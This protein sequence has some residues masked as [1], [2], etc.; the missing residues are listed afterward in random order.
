VDDTLAV[1]RNVGIPDERTMDL[2]AAAPTDRDTLVEA[3]NDI[4]YYDEK[5]DQMMAEGHL[6]SGAPNPFD[7]GP[8]SEDFGPDAGSGQSTAP[9]P[10]PG[11]TDIQLVTDDAGRLTATIPPLTWGTAADRSLP[12]RM[13]LL[14]PVGPNTPDEMSQVATGW[15]TS[16]NFPPGNASGGKSLEKVVKAYER[17]STVRPGAAGIDLYA[18]DVLGEVA[19]YEPLEVLIGQLVWVD[20]AFMQLVI[21]KPQEIWATEATGN[22][23]VSPSPVAKWPLDL[24]DQ[25]A[26]TLMGKTPKVGGP[27]SMPFAFKMKSI[28]IS[29]GVLDDEPV[30]SAVLPAYPDTLGSSGTLQATALVNSIRTESVNGG[31]SVWTNRQVKEAAANPLPMFAR[32]H[33]QAEDGADNSPENSLYVLCAWRADE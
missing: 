15:N 24:T 20:D 11:V 25:S 17:Q 5:A 6:E 31:M 21:H 10:I 13:R 2:L 18:Y 12:F 4:G 32:Y 33:Y 14:A 29:D 9:E 26:W 27:D 19:M 23:S 22:V 28:G 30:L 3:L 16:Q 8:F 1:A 7:G